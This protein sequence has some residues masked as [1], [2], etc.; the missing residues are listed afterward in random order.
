MSGSVVRHG[1]K[2]ERKTEVAELVKDFEL[3]EWFEE[4]CV[5]ARHYDEDRKEFTTHGGTWQV[6]VRTRVDTNLTFGASTPLEAIRMDRDT[7]EGT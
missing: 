2:R 6:L 4:H 1:S 5:A 7:C 3:L